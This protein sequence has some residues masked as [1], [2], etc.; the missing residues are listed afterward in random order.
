[1][2]TLTPFPIHFSE[3]GK[4]AIAVRSPLGI[5]P[6]LALEALGIHD[7][8]GTIVLHGGAAAMSPDIMDDAR[9]FMRDSVVKFAQEHQLLVS[10]GGTRSGAMQ[11]LGDAYTDALAD[12]PLLGLCPIHPVIYPG[13]P[14]DRY[15]LFKP[16]FQVN[17]E[18]RERYPL[19]PNYTHFIL[20]EAENFGS[21]S[22]MMV[23]MLGVFG[24]SGVSII[25][26]GGQI[27]REEAMRQLHKRNPVITVKG[28]G[29]AADEILDPTSDLYQRRPPND[30]LHVVDFGDSAAL[31]EMLNGMFPFVS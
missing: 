21:E 18:K 4:D 25:F 17:D 28:S 5:H 26:N 15:T 14:Q 8:K 6:E 31:F 12:F 3:T 30:T 29:R 22:H 13:H 20:L 11:A 2:I 23:D 9:L 7:V 27:A 1:L 24:R 16:M 19:D 10:F